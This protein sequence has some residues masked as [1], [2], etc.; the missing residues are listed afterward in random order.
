MEPAVP[1]VQ[2][3]AVFGATADFGP[4]AWLRVAG[5]EGQAGRVTGRPPMIWVRLIGL[6]EP[7]IAIPLSLS[8]AHRHCLIPVEASNPSVNGRVALTS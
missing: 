7:A 3:T 5:G 8:G 1:A 2:N 6:L 4:V